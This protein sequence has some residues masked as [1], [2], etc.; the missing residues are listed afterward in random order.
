MRNSL[1]LHTNDEYPPEVAEAHLECHSL[2]KSIPYGERSGSPYQPGSPGAHDLG[3]RFGRVQ[4]RT[5]FKAVICAEYSARFSS[6]R[7]MVV[8]S[9]V[10]SKASYHSFEAVRILPA[11]ARVH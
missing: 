6:M 3:M 2:F 8:S 1:V 9:G 7:A 4:Y 5:H 10:C 11:S